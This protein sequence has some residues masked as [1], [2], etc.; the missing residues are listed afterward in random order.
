M[1]S[2][3]KVLYQ[4]YAASTS[5]KAARALFVAKFGRAPAEVVRTGGGVNVGPLNAQEVNRE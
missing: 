3:D 5:D 1:N 2:K 4:G